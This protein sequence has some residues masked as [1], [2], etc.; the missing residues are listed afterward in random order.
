[1]KNKKILRMIALA[2]VITAAVCCFGGCTN[3]P[4][5]PSPTVDPFDD[6]NVTYDAQ[7]WVANEIVFTADKEYEEP[8]YSTTFE[9]VFTNT[10]TGTTYTVPGFW[11]GGTEWIIRYALTEKGDW[12]YKTTFSDETDSGLN[13]KEGTLKCGAYKGELDIYKHGFI[14]TET[15]KHYFMYADG[16]PF[17]YIGDTHWSLP[18]EEYDGIGDIEQDVADQY[19]I[20]SQFKY[21]MDYRANQGFTVIESQPLSAYEGVTGNSW[22]GDANGDIFTYGVNDFI[23][24]KFK[25]YDKYFE[26][27]A[28]KGF[29]HS[30]SQLSYPEELIEVC[31]GDN[32]TMTDEHLEALCRYWVARYSA[33]PVMWATT[34]E[35][36]ANYYGWGG[37][38]NENNPW[39][40]VFNYI[41]KYDP[42][43]HPASCHQ[44]G[45]R[46]TNVN[47]SV[48]SS[49]DGYTFYAMQYVDEG[50]TVGSVHNFKVLKEYWN[51]EGSLPVVNYEGRYDRFWIGPN[52]VRSQF[53]SAF[54]NGAFGFGYGVQPIWEFFWAAASTEE[55][56][57]FGETF[58]SDLTWLEGLMAEGGREMSY[59]KKFFSG[60]EWWKLEPCFDG[61][62]YFTPMSTN[63][64]AATIGNEL[65]IGYFFNP[66]EYNIDGLFTGMKDGL[67]EIKWYDPHTGEY[68]E[69]CTVTERITNG[70][71][72]IA[73]SPAVSD[74]VVVARYT[75]E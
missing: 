11:N 35:G 39:I 74:W 60:Y 37:C 21:I 15:G 30:H 16:T 36:D 9:A 59:M 26:Y 2:T 5:T 67:Y 47:N 14:K 68:R 33:Y 34:Q 27:I 40:K 6:P 12:I 1:M 62:E 19:G 57:M 45:T 63:Y 69:D 7:Q 54:L 51:N 52:G 32:V 42:Y 64:A 28:E 29:V 13:G 55:K 44:E 46:T 56:N 71:Y 65:Y 50:V 22:F 25:T 3:A 20:T 8:V 4:Q 70:Q 10:T 18:M 17:L 61:N 24:E 58:Q 73:G 43:D 31:I 75:G 23:L 41:Q 49:L 38:T 66:R 72:L 48:F 53:W